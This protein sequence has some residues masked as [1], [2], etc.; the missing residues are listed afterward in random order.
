M[1]E[2]FAHIR[3]LIKYICLQGFPDAKR[4]IVKVIIGLEHYFPCKEFPGING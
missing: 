4:Q 3:K 2:G 1:E